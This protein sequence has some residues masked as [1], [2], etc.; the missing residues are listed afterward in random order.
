M[1]E[2]VDRRDGTIRQV[3]ACKENHFLMWNPVDGW[4]WMYSSN[5]EPYPR[6]RSRGV[7]S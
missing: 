4:H 1:F 7:N 5:F 2:V 6:E 3:Y